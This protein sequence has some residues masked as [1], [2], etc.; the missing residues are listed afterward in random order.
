MAAPEENNNAEKWTLEEST[1]LFDDAIKL[2]ENENRDYDFIGEIAR[3]LNNIKNY[4]AI[5]LI[6]F[7]N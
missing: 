2:S 3:D 7:Q 4:L 6:N 1:K 5:F